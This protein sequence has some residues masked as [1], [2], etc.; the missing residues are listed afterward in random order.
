MSSGHGKSARHT[1]GGEYV[2]AVMTKE[3]HQYHHG[4][5]V[6]LDDEQAQARWGR[7]ELRFRFCDCRGRKRQDGGEFNRKD[8][9]EAWTGAFSADPSAV[10]LDDCFRNSQTKPQ[11]SG[12][13]R[14]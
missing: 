7:L 14:L 2:M 11:A 9:A 5:L 10:R 6:V 1:F 13:S 4:R 8:R 12:G 3:P